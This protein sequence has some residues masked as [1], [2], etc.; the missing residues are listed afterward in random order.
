MML[1]Y[2]F[3]YWA[4]GNVKLCIPPRERLNLKK[5]KNQKTYK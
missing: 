1:A 2:K 5:L 3:P 4:K